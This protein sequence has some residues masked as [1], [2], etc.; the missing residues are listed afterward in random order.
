MHRDLM[1]ILEAALKARVLGHDKVFLLQ[2]KKGLR[3]LIVESVRNPWLRACKALGFEMCFN[4]LRHAWKTNAR[5]S[6]EHPEIEMVIMGHST[7]QRSV[8]ERCGFI[9]DEEL[10]QAVDSMKFYRGKTEIH[11][12]KDRKNCD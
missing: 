3:L 5:P 8:H 1:P 2:D 11:V 7:R 9:S 6:K 10:A 4:D 12:G